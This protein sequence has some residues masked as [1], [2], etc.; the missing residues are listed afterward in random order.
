MT[1]YPS[2]DF[3]VLDEFIQDT[4]KANEYLK[5]GSTYIYVISGTS[6]I[7][8]RLINFRLKEGDD[9]VPFMVASGIAIR[10]KFYKKY[11]DWLA[12]NRGWIEGEY[13]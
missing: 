12:E 3:K 2:I 1:E 8:K 5:I 13:T 10:L 6:D 9:Q 11:F 4:K 7:N